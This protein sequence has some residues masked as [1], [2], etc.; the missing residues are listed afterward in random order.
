MRDKI[1][2]IL[3]FFNK[4]KNNKKFWTLLVFNLLCYLAAFP[5]GLFVSF[6]WWFFATKKIKSKTKKIVAYS[7]IGFI[8]LT[9]SWGVYA[10]NKDPQP[11]LE[12][13]GVENNQVIQ[14]PNFNLTGK[15]GPENFSVYINGEKIDSSNGN[16]NYNYPLEIGENRITVKVSNFKS[17]EKE[18][19][20]IREFS[21][22][23]IAQQEA[24][25]QRLEE[26]QRKREEEEK[27]QAEEELRGQEL[28]PEVQENSINENIVSDKET[29]E[30]VENLYLVTRIV[31][32]DTFEIESG[33]KVRL[34]GIDTPESG[35]CYFYNAKNKLSDLIL[36]KRIKM[37]KDVSETDRYQRL[38]RYIYVDDI[39]I[40]DYLVKEGFANATSY[41]P[42]IK[43]QDQFRESESQARSQNKGLWNACS[44]P[45]P[46]PTK[47]PEN[48]NSQPAGVS[49]QNNSECNIKGNISYSTG[50]K[51]YH[52]PGQRDYEKTV[53]DSS[54]GERYFCSES[55]AVSAGWRKAK[56]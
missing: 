4:N 7:S 29:Q 30:Q 6:L 44:S 20:L 22:K 47:K 45:T 16:F 23:E 18:L 35:D 19:T 1:K 52:V 32:G 28:V 48:T 25:K 43:Y 5:F 37:D 3:A 49:S 10:Y 41:P 24:E 12:L 17:V 40:N 33:E 34:I 46:I 14:S 11:T 8:F 38:L 27:K 55:E 50:E 15:F 51:I 39:F 26:E 13:Q 54:K 56:R 31:D 21:P 53:I 9:T 42:D 2:P 36:N